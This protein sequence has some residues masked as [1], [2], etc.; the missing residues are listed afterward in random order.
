MNF[1]DDIFEAIGQVMR[2]AIDVCA[3]MKKTSAEL[4]ENIRLAVVERHDHS[5][6]EFLNLYI[7]N[8]DEISPHRTEFTPAHLLSYEKDCKINIARWTETSR[9]VQLDAKGYPDISFYEDMEF[10]L[11]KIMN[12]CC[13]K[14]PKSNEIF[15]IRKHDREDPHLLIHGKKYKKCKECDSLWIK[16]AK[17]DNSY[18]RFHAINKTLKTSK[19]S[20]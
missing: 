9:S 13:D 10:L 15:Y 20:D 5:R 1:L 12:P 2:S 16:L 11:G 6:D 3:E 7:N 17:Q 14:F 8:I 19:S 18:N 4:R